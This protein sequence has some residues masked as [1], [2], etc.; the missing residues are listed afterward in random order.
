MA[1]KREVKAVLTLPDIG[2]KEHEIESLKTRFH[3]SLVESTRGIQNADDVV[4]VVVV[5][6]IERAFEE[7]R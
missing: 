1:K 5:V 3:S 2:L 7:A 4:I 6:V